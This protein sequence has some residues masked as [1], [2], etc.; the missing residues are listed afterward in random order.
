MGQQ[1]RS[2]HNHLGYMAKL[3]VEDGGLCA[4]A[5]YR[6]ARFMEQEQ[7]QRSGRR[8]RGGEK[9]KQTV[10]IEHTVPIKALCDQILLGG[11]TEASLHFWLFKCSVCTALHMEEEK[12]IGPGRRSH[13]GALTVGSV[14]YQRPFM[15]YESLFKNGCV[16][17]NVFDGTLVDP[18]TFTFDNHFEVVLRV[19]QEIGATEMYSKL[20]PAII[21]TQDVPV[22]V[23]QTP[24]SRL[25]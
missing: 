1:I 6:S 3:T 16:V 23:A 9:V 13:S 10:H 25:A 20:R 15:R 22:G 14:E 8:K 19:L 2:F 5:I 17:W 7:A 11:F 12:L 21:Q 4:G 18:R 24:E